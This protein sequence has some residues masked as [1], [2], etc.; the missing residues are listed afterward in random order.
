MSDQL[1]IKSLNSL[2]YEVIKG[3]EFTYLLE[4]AARLRHSLAHRSTKPQNVADVI[5]GC[6]A[7]MLITRAVNAPGLHAKLI[8]HLKEIGKGYRAGVL[9]LRDLELKFQVQVLQRIKAQ[10]KVVVLE[11]INSC[12]SE[13]KKKSLK[14]MLLYLYSKIAV[15]FR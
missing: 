10:L 14:G 7:G 3:T 5:R 15:I 13:F 12:V 4:T 9:E 6:L 2:S 8:G 11:F 1:T